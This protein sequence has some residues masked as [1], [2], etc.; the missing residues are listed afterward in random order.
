L[1]TKKH[2]WRYEHPERHFPFYSSAA[3]AEGKVIVGGRDKMVHAIDQKTGSSLWTFVTGA[4]VE[5]SP[6]V[7]GKRVY[8]GSGDGRFYV[9]ELETGA[10][11]WEFD[12]GAPF[13]AS[14][15]IASGRVVIGS[16][17]GVLYAF[18]R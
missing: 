11:V 8:V 2:L 15:A 3:L 5:S 12:A 14:P 7:A 16:Q 17:D 9:L 13:G 10:K 18:G 4:R 1:K 6:A